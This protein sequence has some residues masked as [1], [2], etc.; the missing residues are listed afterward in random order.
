MTDLKYVFL[1]SSISDQKY[2]VF[3]PFLCS[4]FRLWRKKGNFSPLNRRKWLAS[5][6]RIERSDW[7]LGNHCLGES[8]HLVSGMSISGLSQIRSGT[9][10]L[11]SSAGCI[12]DYGE[13]LYWDIST[14]YYFYFTLLYFYLDVCTIYKTIG[15]RVLGILNFSAVKLQHKLFYLNLK[16]QF[17]NFADFSQ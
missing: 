5:W 14:S 13:I 8:R 15:K 2:I 9:K 4:E 11:K 1:L 3:V 6:F 16:V 12:I 7:L 10:A 17:M